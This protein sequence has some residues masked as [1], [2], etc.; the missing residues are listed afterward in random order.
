M[1]CLQEAPDHLREHVGSVDTDPKLLHCVPRPRVPITLPH[2]GV[3]KFWLSDV[4]SITLLSAAEPAIQ[5]RPGC[6]VSAKSGL[7]RRHRLRTDS[8][9]TPPSC[10]HVNLSARGDPGDCDTAMRL[11]THIVPAAYISSSPNTPQ[12]VT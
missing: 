5:K 1:H 8:D 12:C 3:D 6:K 11:R 2:E 4:F 9:L 7:G 10:N